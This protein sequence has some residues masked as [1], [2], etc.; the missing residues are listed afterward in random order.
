MVIKSPKDRRVLDNEIEWNHA[1]RGYDADYKLQKTQSVA[2][3]GFYHA[4]HV[5][6]RAETAETSANEVDDIGTWQWK[7][8][9]EDDI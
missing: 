3:K 5:H 9:S 2:W 1:H 6:V 8:K 4:E 7:Q